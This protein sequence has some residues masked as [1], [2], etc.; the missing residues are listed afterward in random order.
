MAQVKFIGLRELPKAESERVARGSGTMRRLRKVEPSA[1]FWCVVLGFG[2]RGERTSAGV[3][4]C[5]ARSTGQLLVPSSFSDRFTP[6][7][8][9]MF[10]AVL[11]Q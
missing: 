10:R 5:Y 11:A 3:R 9:R 8:A 6:E 4:R 1:M 7:L 2:A